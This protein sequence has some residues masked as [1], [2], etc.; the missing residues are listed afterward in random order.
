[1]SKDVAPKLLSSWSTEKSFEPMLWFSMSWLVLRIP[2]LPVLV[3]EEG[4]R[5]VLLLP[6]LPAPEP[7]GRAKREPAGCPVL[8]GWLE[9]APPEFASGRL[10]R[11]A[12][13]PPP[14]SSSSLLRA[15][16]L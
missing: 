14:P 11:V 4:E 9:K 15:P 13:P 1:M 2:A 10:P 16:T 8:V 12:P 5:P 3:R 7:W 6:V